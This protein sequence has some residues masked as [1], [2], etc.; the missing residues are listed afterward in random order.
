MAAPSFTTVI[1][2]PPPKLNDP[3]D[4]RAYLLTLV[5][6]EKN[7]MYSAYFHHFEY[8]AYSILVHKVTHHVKHSG[9]PGRYGITIRQASAGFD[10]VDWEQAAEGRPD[11][12]GGRWRI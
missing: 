4:I 10:Q 9:I 2:E 11:D 7:L 8:V 12:S 6:V 1:I 5:K 3:A